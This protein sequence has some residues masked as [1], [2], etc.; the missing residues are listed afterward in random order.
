MVF[1]PSR[2]FAVSLAL[3]AAIVFGSAVS[4]EAQFFGRNKIQYENFDWKVLNTPHFEIF[5]YSAEEELAARA[6]VL[7]EDAYLRLSQVFDHELET[8]VP[9]IL[10]ASP[11]DFQQTNIS[12][13][14][15]GEGTGGF[16]EP[17]RKRM[18]LPY[19]GDTAGFVH[20]INHELVHVFMFDIAYRSYKAN[21]ARRR[22]FP[23]PLWFAEGMAEW[24][25]SEWD[26]NADM[27]LRDATIYDWVIPLHQIYGGYQ[28]YKEG[29][30]AMR[31]IAAT[32]GEDKVVEIFKS[33]ER[34]SS[35]DR[36]LQQTIGLDT[37]GLSDEW[38]K[39]LK[40]EYWPL[41]R[42]KQE[43]DQYAR[44]LSDHWE[45]QAYFFQQPSISPDG[46]FI[47]F[48]SDYQGLVDLFVMDAIDGVVI[49]KLITGYRSDRFLSLHSFD[50]SI[51]FSPDSESIAFVAK[52]GMDEHLF[53]VRLSDGE[54]LEDH[55]LW[56]D[57]ARSPEWAPDGKSVVLSGTRGGK[58][59]L[60][61]VQIEDGQISQITD[62]FV[63]EQNPV[64]HPDGEHLIFSAHPAATA[65]VGFVR[66]ESG[67]MSLQTI[68]F[69]N[70]N[71]QPRRT[72]YD[73]ISLHLPTGET[74][75]VV[76][77]AG[78]DKDPFIVDEK[79]MVFVSDLTGVSN[80]YTHDFETGEVRRLSDVLGGIFH[81]SVSRTADRLAFTAF[82]KAGFDIFL[83]ENFTE[84]AARSSHA[85]IP[86]G[87]EVPLRT[88]QYS[89]SPARSGTV[90]PVPEVVGVTAA[91]GGS[92]AP[93]GE[94]SSADGAVIPVVEREPGLGLSVEPD[95]P[96]S[97]GEEEPRTDPAPSDAP[98]LPQPAGSTPDDEPVD[99]GLPD[100]DAVDATPPGARDGRT[101]GT[102][103]D[104]K[105][106][107]SLDPVGSQGGGIY[108]TSGTGLGIANIL[109]MSDLLGNHR[110]QFLIN[111]YGSLQDSDLAFSYY[112]LKRRINFAAG[113]F[114][115]RN[116]LNSNFNS[117]GEIYDSNQ[118][119]SER[120]YGVFGLASYPFSQFNR[121]DFEMQTF[122]SDKTFFEQDPL[123][124]FVFETGRQKDLLIQ[125]T[126]SWV[127]DSSFWGQAG[128]IT[129]SRYVFSFAPA[130][131]LTTDSVDRIT[132]FADYRRYFRLWG[133]NSIA[134][135]LVGATSN[136]GNP[137]DFVIGGPFTL[138]GWDTWDFNRQYIN[139]EK[140]HDNLVGNNMLLTSIE[141]RL[142]VID[143]LIFGW[144]GRWGIGGISG[145]LFY[146]MGAATDG[147]IQFF[148]GSPPGLL[149]LADLNADIGFGIRFGFAGL[150]M[151]FDWAWKT[152][153]SRVANNV[154]FHFS[155]APSF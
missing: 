36:A 31:Y 21:S 67:M 20:V 78:A 23:V 102:V 117:L 96:P 58:T 89:A 16:S 39:A 75:T 79:T 10:Y 9:F 51:G 94:I 53:V 2:H 132:S 15:I 123:T 134:V 5:F 114:H 52:S 72:G 13:G 144:P 35:V 61:L 130:I 62:D 91:G 41:Y 101:V 47:A 104:Y 82:T 54:I 71:A 49:R 44:R 142:P 18:V 129:G 80:L 17:L 136:G 92:P 81:P 99:L 56:M 121:L 60:F 95:D 28:V 118:L 137:R 24:F 87:T 76:A 105:I 98:P 68:D 86:E 57:I 111:F 122:V 19:P 108:Y 70:R 124:F 135:K 1:L 125:P 40:R 100:E 42:D 149:K 139:G 146:D 107:F 140:V 74:E 143:A 30:S 106:R 14:L 25:S 120:N 50:S 141:Y 154:Q 77:T 127:H 63:D 34:T 152:D 46:R 148:E 126:L 112:Y 84:K 66:D 133:R 29:Q 93:T 59:D 131:P 33:L 32:Y 147:A 110:M 7:A 43:P 88:R 73:L 48:F 151:K 150:P 155:I 26:N 12:D 37:K 90:S 83:L 85:M 109:S 6:A 115:Y 69:E 103:D 113:V 119:F 38:M 3:L 22:W 128:P 65:E 4:A 27:W 8:Q 145:V 55:G 116:F 11:N 138:R 97:R 45:E 153:L 64:W